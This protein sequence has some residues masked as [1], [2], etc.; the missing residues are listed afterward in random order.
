ML[1]HKKFKFVRKILENKQINNMIK[2][3]EK[4]VGTAQ[5]IRCQVD[6]HFCQKHGIYNIII[7]QYLLNYFNNIYY[8][9]V[10]YYFINI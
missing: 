8:H 6:R 2:T 4:W 7:Y 1:E 3:I 10:L 9:I 5:Y